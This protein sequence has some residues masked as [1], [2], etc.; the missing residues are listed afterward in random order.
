MSCSAELLETLESRLSDVL[1]WKVLGKQGKITALEITSL[2]RKL[3]ARSGLVC[4]HKAWNT[5]PAAAA[6]HCLLVVQPGNGAASKGKHP[7]SPGRDPQ[8]ST[9]HRDSVSSSSKEELNAGTSLFPD[10]N[11]DVLNERSYQG[12]S[13]KQFGVLPFFPVFFLLSPFS[14]CLTDV[15]VAGL[16]LRP[17][18]CTW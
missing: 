9:I 16:A 1:V 6:R 17:F 14:H 2:T 5:C 11:G 18:P 10:G 15:P 8:P 7:C 4:L 3:G 12:F 13:P